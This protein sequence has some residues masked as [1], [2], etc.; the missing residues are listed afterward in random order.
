MG[1]ISNSTDWL[2]Q[3]VA[4]VLDFFF[5]ESDKCSGPF[6]PSLNTFVDIN[7]KN[8]S[9]WTRLFLADIEAI[10]NKVFAYD[11]ISL[12]LEE[13]QGCLGQFM[14]SPAFYHETLVNLC[15]NSS[16][17]KNTRFI[18]RDL[19]ESFEQALLSEPGFLLENIK[20]DFYQRAL[21]FYH[22]DST[23]AE[24]QS[25]LSF[26]RIYFP[27]LVQSLSKKMH[28]FVFNRRNNE[29]I[30]NTVLQN[31]VFSLAEWVRQV[32][33]VFSEVIV[34]LPEDVLT[35]VSNREGTKTN[36]FQWSEVLPSK[37]TMVTAALL[38]NSAAAAAESTYGQDN[39]ASLSTQQLLT[40]A[41]PSAS[42]KKLTE[43]VVFNYAN[44]EVKLADNNFVA[45]DAKTQLMNAFVADNKVSLK[46]RAIEESTVI[47]AGLVR[48]R[49]DTSAV[50]LTTDSTQS[51]PP[52]LAQTVIA[53]ENSTF[54]AIWLG[55]DSTSY[56][57]LHGQKFN[58]FGDAL[59]RNMVSI[60]TNLYGDQVNPFSTNVNSTHLAVSWTSA[61]SWTT[62][63][64]VNRSI[65]FRILRSDYLTS[66]MADVL[67]NEFTS[68][69]Y[70]NSAIATVN[71]NELLV[72]WNGAGIRARTFDFQGNPTR[73]EF[74]V[75]ASETL[76][77]APQVA[78]LATDGRIFFTWISASSKTAE[79]RIYTRDLV[80]LTASFSLNV[81]SE[82]H[83]EDTIVSI[84]PFEDGTFLT[85][86]LADD[87]TTYNHVYGRLF[88]DDGL[89]VT[90]SEFLISEITASDNPNYPRVCKLSENFVMVSWELSYSLKIYTQVV[91]K[92]GEM[93]GF[94]PL[95]WDASNNIDKSGH[96]LA[97]SLTNN[98]IYMTW[99]DDRNLYG[100]SFSTALEIT[101][102]N[103]TLSCSNDSCRIF[104]L[105]IDPPFFIDIVNVTFTLM[106]NTLGYL[107]ASPENY[108]SATSEYN[109]TIGTWFAS[110]AYADV[111]YL[112]NN[113][114][115]S[116]NTR[117]YAHTI[118]ENVVEE[119]F[120]DPV[121]G[122]IDLYVNPNMAPSKSSTISNTA[123][124]TETPSATCS[125]SVSKAAD[126]SFSTTPSH[127]LLP[128]LSMTSTLSAS[129]TKSMS[130]SALV[131]QSVTPPHSHSIS[132]S[133]S[134][135]VQSLSLSSS[136]ESISIDETESS[137]EDGSMPGWAWGV[138]AGIGVGSSCILVG[139]ILGCL[140]GGL[141]EAKT[142]FWAKRLKKSGPKQKS[143][144]IASFENDSFPIID[145]DDPNAP[146]IE[147]PKLA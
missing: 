11:E 103:Q 130:V 41:L 80:P 51:S 7:Y 93:I 2:L 25:D 83:Q 86:W 42:L 91:S 3:S 69:F 65:Y 116:S 68:K 76:G 32:D 61:S 40:E 36:H 110:G 67:V 64:N 89:P 30:E 136:G 52:P 9:L 20:E 46:E 59:L 119:A 111:N 104:T 57:D 29:L 141:I 70:D 16:V 79:G 77:G 8:K 128:S 94:S 139:G 56:K 37:K 12:L 118:I 133:A 34:P 5:S 19:K 63:S 127:S 120:N 135:I 134:L 90:E 147:L 106:N 71:N 17:D 144:P 132:S 84:V 98:D 4:P 95:I 27:Q 82:P 53:T 38:L 44:S 108:G 22:G 97:V 10:E 75:T 48:E 50:I 112:L 23:V 54:V 131:T 31:Q 125:P 129:E 14:V 126:F 33:E 18:V 115:F 6:T 62:V 99:F 122:I 101:N 28:Q 140:S 100:Q 105:T 137:N 87:D 58:N 88:Y 143:K 142:G 45:V 145:E 13:W 81:L 35:K 114:F 47:D 49:E 66:N 73:N 113:L 96:P 26:Y 21:E 72:T 55:R 39:S 123:T 146:T 117:D 1:F 138:L 74:L 102:N 60:N 109:S 43:E 107:Y 92:Q 121:R 124:V 78:Q 85:V 24:W 15:M